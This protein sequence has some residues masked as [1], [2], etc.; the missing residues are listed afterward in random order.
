MQSFLLNFLGKPTQDLTAFQKS[1]QD[2]W[3]KL[4]VYAGN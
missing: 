3:D 2:F 4:P 1:I